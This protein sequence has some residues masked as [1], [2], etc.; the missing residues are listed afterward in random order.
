MY[1]IEGINS[2]KNIGNPVFDISIKQRKYGRK[3]KI[4]LIKSFKPDIEIASRIGLGS[5]DLFEI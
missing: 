4:N 1:G 3:T 5:C 2:I